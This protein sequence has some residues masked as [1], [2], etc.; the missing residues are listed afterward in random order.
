LIKGLESTREQEY[1]NVLEVVIGL[2]VLA[3]L[4]TILLRHDD[5]AQ[6]DV[7]LDGVDFIDCFLPV[8]DS[9]ELEVFV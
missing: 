8:A 4:V 6:Y 3:H 7:G 1:R 9:M 2:D 5:V